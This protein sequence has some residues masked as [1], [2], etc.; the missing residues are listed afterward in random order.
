MDLN[1]DSSEE[2]S[3][4]V[5]KSRKVAMELTRAGGKDL[6]SSTE[7]DLVFPQMSSAKRTKRLQKRNH[8]VSGQKKKKSNYVKHDGSAFVTKRRKRPKRNKPTKLMCTLSVLHHATMESLTKLV[9]D[10]SN[11]NQSP[12]KL[13]DS[14][15]DTNSPFPITVKAPD[16]EL[17]GDKSDD[18]KVMYE[19]TMLSLAYLSP[20]SSESCSVSPP[21]ALSPEEMEKIDETNSN[22]VTEKGNTSVECNEQKLTM[23]DILSQMHNPFD[24]F[25]NK[26]KPDESTKHNKVAIAKTT[27]LTLQDI[28]NLCQEKLVCNTG[29]LLPSCSNANDSISLADIDDK[30]EIQK[31][32]AKSSNVKRENAKE[33]PISVLVSN[34][35]KIATEDCQKAIDNTSGCS[36]WVDS[37]PP[38]LGPPVGSSTEHEDKYDDIPPHLT[39]NR[40]KSISEC[41]EISNSDEQF[42]NLNRTSDRY[43]RIHQMPPF[44]T[45]CRSPRTSV[46]PQGESK[47]AENFVKRS[48]QIEEKLNQ[49]VCSENSS[50]SM[51]VVHCKDFS[52]I[53]DE[54][55]ERSHGQGH[56]QRI[57]K[58][59]AGTTQSINNSES[60]F[61]SYCTEYSTQD[62]KAI[63]RET[64]LRQ[65]KEFEEQMANKKADENRNNIFDIFSVEAEGI[66]R[67]TSRESDSFKYRNSLQLEAHCHK[68][69]IFMNA[70]QEHLTSPQRSDRSFSK[71]LRAVASIKN[72]SLTS[73]APPV[74]F[75]LPNSNQRSVNSC[76]QGRTE[77]PRSVLFQRSLSQHDVPSSLY[78]GNLENGFA[79]NVHLKDFKTRN[80]SMN[81]F[82]RLHA[83]T[84]HR[85][86]QSFFENISNGIN[87]FSNQIGHTSVSGYGGDLFESSVDSV[88]SFNKPRPQLQRP[89]SENSQRSKYG[90]VHNL[91]M[92]DSIRKCV[93]NFVPRE[94]N[95]INGPVPFVS[96]GK[97]HERNN[98][99]SIRLG[100]SSKDDSYLSNNTSN[101]SLSNS[102]KRD[103]GPNESQD[104]G[105]GDHRYKESMEIVEQPAFHVITPLICPPSRESVQITATEHGLPV[106][107]LVH[108]FYGNHRDVPEKLREGGGHVIKVP[109][110]LVSEL[111]EFESAETFVTGLKN[112]R[113]ILS[114]GS[115]MS[116]SQ[117]GSS[118]LLQKLDQEPSMR[119]AITGDQS[120]IITPCL[121]PPLVKS[122]QQW[123][124]E[125]T[126]SVSVTK[127]ENKKQI[128]DDNSK[129]ALNEDKQKKTK[130]ENNGK[131]KLSVGIERKNGSYRLNLFT[132]KREWTSQSDS[133]SPHSSQ[134]SEVK[135]LKTKHFAEKDNSVPTK[136]DKEYDDEF[137]AIKTQDDSHT[138]R[139]RKLL[140]GKESQEDIADDA[141]QDSGVLHSTP[142]LRR[143]STELFDSA[144]TPITAG[145]G[146]KQ[147]QGSNNGAGAQEFVT[148]KPGRR[149]RRMSTNTETTLRRALLSTHAKKFGS[150]SL[151]REDTS[152]IEGP[153]LKNSF[154][155]RH[156][157]QYVQDAKALHEFQYLTIMSVEIHA[158]TRGDLRPDP[159]HDPIQ[160]IFYSIFNDVPPE[161]GTRQ[162]SGVFIVHPES[163]NQEQGDTCSTSNQMSD[164]KPVR[165]HGVSQN[166]KGKANVKIEATLLEKSAIHNIDVKY[167]KDENDLLQTFID[168]VHKWDPDILV[169]YE[170]QML[171]WGYLLQRAATL[172]LNLA[173]S[174]S[175]VPS[176]KQSSHHSAEK[177]EYGADHMSEIHI[178]GRIVLNLWRVLR[179]EVTLNI[180]SFENVVFHVLHR[181]IPLYSF[182]SLTSWFKH[183]THLHRWKVVDHYATQVKCNLQL[184][185]QLDV[186][187]RTSEFAR[188]FGIEFYH[189]LSRGSQY[190]VESMMLRVAKPMNYIPA[191]PSVLQR[192]RMKAPECIPL[193]LEPESRFYTDP[194]IILDFQSLYPS[195]MIAYNYCFS[196]CLGRLKWFDKAHEGPIEFGCTSLKLEPSVIKKLSDKV[197]VSPNG[198]VFCSQDVKRGVLPIMVEEILN[199]RLMVKKAMGS[200]KD[201]KT[202][203]RML[204]ARQLGLKLIANVTYGYTAANFSGRMPCIEVGDSIVRKARETLE[205][206][207]R[208]VEET[209]RWG[210]KVVYG[211]TDSMFILLK[212]KSKDEAF[213]IGYDIA[214]TVT[215]MFPKPIKLKFEKVYLPCVLQ[216]KKRYVGFMYETPDQKEPVYDAKGIETV[217]RDTCSAVSKMLER[218]IKILFTTKDVSQ[219]KSYVQRQC[220]KVM[221]GRVS[222]QDFVF[223]KEYRGMPGYKPGACVPAL[224]IAKKSI[225]QDRRSEPRVGERVPYVI[226]Y[227]SPGLPLI[228]LVRSPSDL[229]ADPSLR[230]NAVYYITK[231]ILPPLDRFLFLLGADVFS[232]YQEMPHSAGKVSIINTGQEQAKKGT[233]SQYFATSNCPICDGQTKQSIC[234]NCLNDPQMVCVTLNDRIN[235]WECVYSNVMK[236]CGTCT[237]TSE[238]GT[239]NACVSLD[240]PIL[241][242]KSRAAVDISRAQVYRDILA[243][244]FM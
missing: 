44:L 138:E 122:V 150:P 22:G 173:N 49:S 8:D 68:N 89:L 129:L 163:A 19:D 69:G 143:Q 11:S 52:D 18:H 51:N 86:Q 127:T 16:Y 32:E 133:D 194:V 169:G 113:I 103:K 228:Q 14:L 241:F 162:E 196:T 20:F 159:E 177:D 136:H 111:E 121:L 62:S 240:C 57:L 74:S 37:P 124:K 35:G 171:S 92:C 130:V 165:S 123:L 153:S 10:E 42:K 215:N 63:D 224:E 27:T 45:P 91:K 203:S 78:F 141:S 4:G 208:L 24:S 73:L 67:N 202:L 21:R 189:V 232:W 6:S 131:S 192:A 181:R 53:S 30:E 167:V 137:T 110:T 179:H 59:G 229:L 26:L 46:S 96:F 94:D 187:G 239:V 176:A 178:A 233:I 85:S 82:Q 80:A 226:V 112:W 104:G 197:S 168:F 3:C 109:S 70:G 207:I 99:E 36:R 188:V 223:A 40:N 139:E 134:E 213:K 195:I 216:T 135:K 193:T 214:K 12:I 209:P 236:V 48:Q 221:E 149:M 102:H 185:D 2:G 107:Q 184:L 106:H 210:A 54:D 231:Q 115:Q 71:K 220:Q 119:Y 212:G 28:K 108:A 23:M 227:G 157:Q 146:T 38:D 160:A 1:D 98:P 41:S 83:E 34:D 118:D 87:N 218:A 238:P 84:K 79:E 211:D 142:L 56:M 95:G 183:R 198:V 154:G 170:I 147:S 206:S 60:L 50:E 237:G 174:I 17:Y 81:M 116:S 126:K 155:F 114:S 191:S 204:N 140:E 13:R 234:R 244:V 88:L 145:L 9:S 29:P 75:P 235:K 225:R 132:G 200:Y 144:C 76:L 101:S 47:I 219:V 58:L 201:D 93:N 66:E 205:R 156:S 55:G 186:I 65:I 5:A 243:N 151:H 190:R 230:L 64:K 25:G 39:P 117:T 222:L 172:S 161:Q 72:S 15:S 100:D 175:R 43:N 242:R 105:S 164:D 61:S 97:G 152:Q 166:A 33:T 90:I 120:V 125:K 148:P 77:I 199:T 128:S 7:E 182:R 180:Y 217:R 158:E 31:L